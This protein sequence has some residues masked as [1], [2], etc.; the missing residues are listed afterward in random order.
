M[1]PALNSVLY[2]AILIR[3]SEGV[4]VSDACSEYA[5]EPK[6]FY[7]AR[8]RDPDLQAAFVEAQELG[9]ECLADS[10]QNINESIGNPLMAR[11]VSEN[12]RWLLARRFADRYGDKLAVEDRRGADLTDILREAIARIPRPA[13]DQPKTIEARTVTAA[14]I[15]GDDAND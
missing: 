10:L 2:D 1:L 6:E 9:A 15:L 11:V 13:S 8:K 14:D 12:R 5:V 3:I 4:S 7:R